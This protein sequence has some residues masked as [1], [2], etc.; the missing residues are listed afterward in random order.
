MLGTLAVQSVVAVSHVLGALT[1]KE[2]C[3][4]SVVISLHRSPLDESPRI[5]SLKNKLFRDSSTTVEQKAVCHAIFALQCEAKAFM[6]SYRIVETLY[7][8]RMR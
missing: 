5:K 8:F 4:I 6:L 3:V 2:Y 7:C 1:L